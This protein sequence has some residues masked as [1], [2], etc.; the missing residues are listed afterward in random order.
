MHG[1]RFKVL[2]NTRLSIRFLPY[3]LERVGGVSRARFLDVRKAPKPG[4]ASA[5]LGSILVRT[6]GEEA[7]FLNFD[8]QPCTLRT[9]CDDGAEAIMAF[10]MVPPT[11][12]TTGVIT[13]AVDYTITEWAGRVGRHNR[14]TQAKLHHYPEQSGRN[15][16][17]EGLTGGRVEPC[18]CTRRL[19][20][21]EV[22]PGGLTVRSRS[23]E[24]RNDHA[25]QR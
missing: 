13:K 11:G 3:S 22:G 9:R 5:E 12:A 16:K 4:P 14:Q 19:K 6:L 20:E 25:V 18:P 15:V 23:Q 8:T 1:L 24:L 2:N 17:A 10:D 7:R 21:A